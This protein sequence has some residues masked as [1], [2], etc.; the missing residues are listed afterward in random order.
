MSDYSSKLSEESDSYF[1]NEPRVKNED[2]LYKCWNVEGDSNVSFNS[3][4][5]KDL[6][7]SIFTTLMILRIFVLFPFSKIFKNPYNF[8]PVQW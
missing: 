3:K 1:L 7:I 2:G 8:K 5:D 6:F 4:I